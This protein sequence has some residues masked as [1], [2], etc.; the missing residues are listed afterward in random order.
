MLRML[1]TD[2]EGGFHAG[3]EWSSAIRGFPLRKASRE[4]ESEG[5]K[6]AQ[7]NILFFPKAPG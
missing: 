7:K 5:P 2:H 1:C 3:P 6:R 4:G